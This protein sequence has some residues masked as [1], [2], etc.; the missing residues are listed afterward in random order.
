M[1]KVKTISVENYQAKGHYP[2]CI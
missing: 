2:E 1:K